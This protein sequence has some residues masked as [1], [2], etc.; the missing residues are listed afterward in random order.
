MGDKA[1]RQLLAE[2]IGAFTLIFAGTGSV[3]LA[4]ANTNV[5][6]VGVALAH[7]LAIALMISALGPISGGHFN[8]AVTIGFWVTRRISTM[9]AAAY[10]IAQLLG[11]IIASLL[12]M[13]LFPEGLRN[14]AHLGSPG[15]GAGIDF[16]H[17]V[18]IEAVLTFFLVTVIW[19][20]AVDPRAPKL[21]GLAIGLTITM[22]ILAAGPLTGAVMNPARA[23]GPML[24]SGTWDNM[25]VWWIGPII[26]AVIAALVY[27][28]LL[29]E[30]PMTSPAR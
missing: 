12:V 24:V 13:L 9:L 15:L 28:Y 30:E 25:L 3:M 27:H 29:I 18:G 14:A 20:T 22:D 19:G 8:P 16:L 2:A 11:A 23:L 1:P 10:I 21:G 17:A 26:G 6:L 4:S 5:T 7:G